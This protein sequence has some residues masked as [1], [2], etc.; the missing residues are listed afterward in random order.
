[1]RRVWDEHCI[2]ALDSARGISG[3]GVF[4]DRIEFIKANLFD[5]MGKNGREYRSFCRLPSIKTGGYEHILG[6]SR[7]GSHLPRREADR[8][9]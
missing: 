9:G 3:R 2:I 1:M 4:H 8:I 7:G 6:H 5:V